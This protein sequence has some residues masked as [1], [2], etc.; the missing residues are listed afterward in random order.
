MAIPDQEESFFLIKTSRP[1]IVSP[2]I[3]N[4]REA[5]A[6]HGICPRLCAPLFLI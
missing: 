6:F 1:R 5:K 4:G 2:F 3:Y